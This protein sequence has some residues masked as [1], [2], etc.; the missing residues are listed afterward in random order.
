MPNAIRNR[1][2]FPR[3]TD[4]RE[5]FEFQ[6]RWITPE[7]AHRECAAMMARLDALPRETRLHIYEHNEMPR[8]KK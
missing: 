7:E 2:R 5:G 8:E 3:P 6:G 1:R 4:R